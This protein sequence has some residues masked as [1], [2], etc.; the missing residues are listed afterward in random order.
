MSCPF[1][2]YNTIGDVDTD[3][4][5]WHAHQLKREDVLR[6]TEMDTID[7]LSEYWKEHEKKRT[8]LIED[9]VSGL[10]VQFLSKGKTFNGIIT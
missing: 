8:Q 2:H 9:H 5:Q 3:I 7:E 10:S 6:H 4:R 1:L